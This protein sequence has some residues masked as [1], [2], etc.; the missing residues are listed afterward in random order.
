MSTFKTTFLE[1]FRTNF[2]PHVE[3]SVILLTR[4]RCRI[5]NINSRHH[6]YSFKAEDTGEPAG[7]FQICFWYFISFNMKSFSAKIFRMSQKEVALNMQ[8]FLHNIL[9]TD[10]HDI[11]FE[12]RQRKI[13]IPLT[14]ITD[15][16][17]ES[18]TTF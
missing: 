5:V 6:T 4:E 3:Q 9:F 13:H 7:T 18:I 2:L 8:V 14:N 15:V 11:D 16:P 12:R 1:C 17:L 10:E